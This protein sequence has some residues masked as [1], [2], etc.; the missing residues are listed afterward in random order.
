MTQ[1]VSGKGRWFPPESFYTTERCKRCGICCGS[2]D[3]HPCEHLALKQ[4]G[5]YS[6]E[7]YKERLGPHRTVD[8]R[9]FVCVPIKVLIESNGGYQGCAYVEEI[10][11][12]RREM[13][14]P[15]DDLGR[16]SFPQCP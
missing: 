10:R 15:V 2:T 12:V 8:G 3:G 13:G 4:D 5:A 14:Q 6:C 1:A 9:R 7:I 11:Q 16:L